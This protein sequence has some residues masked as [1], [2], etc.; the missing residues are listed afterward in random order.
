MLGAFL[1]VAAASPVVDRDD[2]PTSP[3]V[4][5]LLTDLYQISMAYAYWRAGR[6]DDLAVF[7]LFFRHNPFNGC[8]VSVACALDHV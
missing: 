5:P 1:M 3:F 2:A 4:T 6:H 8:S 7:D